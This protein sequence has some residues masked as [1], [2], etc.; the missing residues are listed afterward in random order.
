M[1]AGPWGAVVAGG[2]VGSAARAGLSQSLP[3]T[4]GSFPT[5][6]LIVNLTGALLLGLYL[7]RRE[8]A[9]TARWSL[10]FWAVGVFGSF[11]TFSALSI[12]VVHLLEGGRPLV[13]GGYVLASIVGGLGLALAGQRV[14]SVMG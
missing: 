9:T 3:A 7:A 2:L 10:Q 13:A 5:A 6:T 4:S 11:T 8:R 12:E 14:G 1:T